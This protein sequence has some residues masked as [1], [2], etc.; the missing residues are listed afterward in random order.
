MSIRGGF[1]LF[2]VLKFHWF[3]LKCGRLPEMPQLNCCCF[4]FI[5]FVLMTVEWR[6]GLA[7]HLI[8]SDEDVTSVVQG[9]WKRLNTLQHYKVRTDSTIASSALSSSTHCYTSFVTLAPSIGTD[10]DDAPIS[11]LLLTVQCVQN[12]FCSTSSCPLCW[13]EACCLFWMLIFVCV[14]VPDGATVALVPRLTK[15]IHRENQD[16]IPGESEFDVCS[17]KII[18]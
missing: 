17:Y 5:S 14:Q 9:T 18:S 8:L 2:S 10:S 4:P 16:Y 3:R 7:G 12:L 13:W 1:C 6:S 15:H 11:L